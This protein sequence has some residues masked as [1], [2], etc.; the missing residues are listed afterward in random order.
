MITLKLSPYSQEEVDKLAELLE[1]MQPELQTYCEKYT[2][3]DECPIRHLCADVSR[4]TFYAEEYQ[5]V[6]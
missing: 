4:A 5:S 1:S 6:R 3:C 2:L